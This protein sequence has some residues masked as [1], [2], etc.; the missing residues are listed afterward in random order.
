V[1]YSAIAPPLSLNFQGVAEVEMGFR[2][3]GHDAD[4]RIV[5]SIRLL[6]LHLGVRA[7][8]A[9]DVTDREIG[10]E[11]DSHAV[12]ADRLI[13]LSLDSK[14]VPE[15]G[16]RLGEVDC[17]AKFDDRLLKLFVVAQD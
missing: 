16:V 14:G 11:L 3:V 12:F 4:P 5:I 13:Q 15:V 17:Y 2:E 9:V 1:R 7:D 8:A 6:Q 10:L